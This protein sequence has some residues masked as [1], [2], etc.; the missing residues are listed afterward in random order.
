MKIFTCLANLLLVVLVLLIS[1][2]LTHAA[3]AQLE[4]RVSKSLLDPG[5]AYILYALKKGGDYAD[6]QGIL[7]VNIQFCPVNDSCGPTQTVTWSNRKLV[8]GKY[9]EKLFPSIG[10]GIYKARYRPTGGSWRGEQYDWSNG[11][12]IFVGKAEFLGKPES[13]REE[14]GLYDTSKFWSLDNPAAYP[15]IFRG[16]NNTFPVSTAIQQQLKNSGKTDIPNHQNSVPFRTYFNITPKTNLCGDPVYTMEITKER[17]EAYWG[18]MMG[19]GYWQP[20]FNNRFDIRD[21]KKENGWHD[22]YLTGM[23]ER[24]Y[25]FKAD[26]TL[27]PSQA[28]GDIFQV[29]KHTVSNLNPQFPGYILGPKYVANGWG[30]DS[31]YADVNPGLDTYCQAQ[32]GPDSAENRHPRWFIS[33]DFYDDLSNT[34]F[35]SR[36]PNKKILRTRI[37]EGQRTYKSGDETKDGAAREDWYLAKDLGVVRITVEDLTNKPPAITGKAC[38]NNPECINDHLSN[39]DIT[40]TRYSLTD[41]ISG[42]ANADGI[43]NTQDAVLLLNKYGNNGG[44]GIGL[45]GDVGSFDGP[46][47]VDINRDSKVNGWDYVELL[48]NFGK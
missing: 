14:L 4:V 17:N 24:K 30:I 36:Y 25:Y 11:V 13:V 19:T 26:K 8:D 43:V 32:A 12:L 42:D 2:S 1:P 3:G 7:D 33:I 6:Y 37:I 46:P 10:K 41:R 48:S 47:V 38:R 40:L 20:Y 45:L 34:K 28:F 29:K 39:P 18:P 9:T 35:K 15:A 31:F 5:E 22:E 16:V 44:S 23:G 27:E 21:F